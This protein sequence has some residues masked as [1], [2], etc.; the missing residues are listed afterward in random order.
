MSNQPH[1]TLNLLKINLY[2][3]EEISYNAYAKL[4]LWLIVPVAQWIERFPAKEEARG[5]NPLGHTPRDPPAAN[6]RFSSYRSPKRQVPNP[7]SRSY[8]IPS[9]NTRRWNLVR[10]SGGR[11]NH[12]RGR[13][14]M[15][16]AAYA[17][18]PATS[19]SSIR[20]SFREMRAAAI[21]CSSSALR[22]WN[23]S[24]AT[25][26]SLLALPTTNRTLATNA[27]DAPLKIQGTAH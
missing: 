19:S 27:C 22:S 13:S 3:L 11:S 10:R 17:S 8:G 4:L 16:A 24:F 2:F 7:P 21:S 23:S 12:C 5:S 20:H 25:P 15:N 18:S 26:M 1:C 9:G 14:R 6:R